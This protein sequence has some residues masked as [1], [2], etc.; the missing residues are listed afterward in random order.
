MLQNDFAL[1]YWVSLKI[2]QDC[3]WNRIGICPR[4]FETSVALL[5]LCF[6]FRCDGETGILLT[7]N[8][9][10]RFIDLREEGTAS[11]RVL[12]ESPDEVVRYPGVQA[13]TRA[14]NQIQE[15]WCFNGH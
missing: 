9:A 3:L 11:A 14:L 10:N 13:A 15:P 5:Q 1:R 4:E 12:V 7:S 6:G 8:E 2:G